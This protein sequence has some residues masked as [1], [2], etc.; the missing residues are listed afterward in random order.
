MSHWR[1][2]SNS[3]EIFV[4]SEEIT[5]TKV[6][7]KFISDGRRDSVLI[8]HFSK[9]AVLVNNYVPIDKEALRDYIKW[10]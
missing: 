7:F 10:K 2:K 3:V 9:P 6:R 5:E 8:R 4:F 1:S